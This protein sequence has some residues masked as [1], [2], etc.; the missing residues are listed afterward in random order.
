MLKVT[1]TF[2]YVKHLI[3][4]RPGIIITNVCNLS[5][6][7][8]Y[9]Q[10]GKFPKDKLW[11]IPLNQLRENIEYIAKY[12]YTGETTLLNG[13]K[14]AVNIEN[15]GIDLIGGEPTIH[16]E[17]ESI[18]KI[19]TE[20]YANLKFMISTNGRIPA[21]DASNVYYHLDYKT[22]EIASQHDFA[23]TLVAPIDIVENS[24]QLYYWESAQTDCS[25][26]KLL[27]CVNPIYNNQISIC[28]VAASW[29]DL[30]DLDLG[31]PLNPNKNPFANLTD[32]NVKDK[33]FKVCYRCGWSKR[34]RLPEEQ[35]SESYN[36]VSS[37][38]LEV[39]TKNAKD[40][41]YKLVSKE[42][43]KIKISGLRNCQEL[44][45]LTFRGKII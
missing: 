3:G 15:H 25:I 35:R 14:V 4:K 23:P 44:I 36:L 10:C 24:N 11:F 16:P 18:W 37:T 12:M 38:N 20:E 34:L 43:G 28:S 40:K 29:N 9:A 42:E 8:C 30:L 13:E 33:A 32:K 1:N 2:K 21:R 7:G 5:C 31:W 41:P 39:L 26:W 6:G 27:S 22:K 45:Q 17:W 19:I